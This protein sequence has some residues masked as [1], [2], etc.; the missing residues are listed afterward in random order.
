MKKLLCAAIITVILFILNISIATTPVHAWGP[1]FHAE[2]AVNCL[3][4]NYSYI[5]SYNAR[6]GS[7]TP[8]FFWQLLNRGL[9]TE[10]TADKL[11]GLTEQ[12]CVDD[13]TVYL[14]GI[15]AD[16]LQT[17]PWFRRGRLYYF[18]QGIGTHVYADI[19]AHSPSNGYIELWMSKFREKVL[20]YVPDEPLHLALEFSL[21][22]ILAEHG[23]LLNDLLFCYRQATFL[24]KVVKMENGDDP[25]FD[26]SEEFRKYLALMRALE[27]LAGLYF[28]YLT[29]EIDGGD[30]LR[31]E[32]SALVDPN[33]LTI[34]LR[35]PD[36][37]YGTLIDEN[38]HWETAL[39]DAI[40]FCQT[41]TCWDGP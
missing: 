38:L 3:G 14:Y 2:V 18:V 34:L 22:A 41:P 31:S 26:V 24:E 30:L 37:I 23:F 4:L 9:I 8:D 11:H 39:Y 21:D 27:K 33:V 12:E 29:G 5:R 35:Y 32:E 19:V 36:E 10:D 13:D 40:S 20:E 17:E 16:A 6:M 1:R 28:L 25:G 15:A 7:L